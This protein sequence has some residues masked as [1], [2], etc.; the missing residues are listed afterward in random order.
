M[1]LHESW[2]VRRP[3]DT[4]KPRGLTVVRVPARFDFIGGWTDTP[5]YYFD[6]DAS[7]LNTT[8][9]LKRLGRAIESADDKVITV[10]VQPADDWTVYENGQPLVANQDHI[11]LNAVKD[12]LGLVLPPIRISIDNNI[13]KGSGLGGSSLL[14]AAIYAAL[15]SY[16]EGIDLSAAKMRE[17]VDA[18]LVVEQMMTSGGGWQDQIGG[19][20]GGVKLIS[21]RANQ[22]GYRI[23]R[24]TA[25]LDELNRRSLVVNSNQQRRAA[26]ILCSI[27]EKCIQKDETALAL[28]AE[29][30]AA[31][32]HG[33]QLLEDGQIDDF[34][35]LYSET[36]QKVNQVETKTSI[37]LVG[38]LEQ[39]C[40]SD[41]L[42]CKIG[43]AGGGG[44]V[45]MTFTNEQSRNKAA[46]DIAKQMPGS[47]I[48][49]PVFGGPGIEVEQN[50]QHET[51]GDWNEL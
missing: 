19:V 3:L 20:L 22:D 24:T 29:I 46:V 11:V 1:F 47:D 41:L 35:R 23:Q 49:E 44:F 39:L 21:T 40:G 8:V 50:S 34:A 45:V 13:P 27:R 6:H 12:V 2:S 4:T 17:L 32:D 5:P 18:I 25:S 48:F 7:V 30:R 26:M 38:E 10:A 9:R 37:P 43:G 42:G 31:A 15:S 33:F 14:A 28:M 16:Y 51:V 36:W